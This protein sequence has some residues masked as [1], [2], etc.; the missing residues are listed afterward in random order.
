MSQPT[1]GL[2][3]E[4]KMAYKIAVSAPTLRAEINLGLKQGYEGFAQE[5][6]EVLTFLTDR[7]KAAV[8]E[9]SNFVPYVITDSVIAYAYP[10]DSGPV[11]AHEPALVLTSDKSPLYAADM[12]EDDW[13]DAVRADAEALG[14]R[15]QQFRVYVTFSSVACTIL[16]KED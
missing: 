3:K 7:Y 2:A 1:V 10:G 6:G 11:A 16:Q 15:F 13:A 5:K 8:G 14:E 9:G 4:A 12:S